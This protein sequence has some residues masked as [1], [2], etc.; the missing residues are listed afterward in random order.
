METKMVLDIHSGQDNLSPEEWSAAEGLWTD[1]DAQVNAAA[2]TAVEVA[3]DGRVKDE[4]VPWSHEGASQELYNLGTLLALKPDHGMPADVEAFLSG[5]LLP[6]G[7]VAPKSWPS[8]VRA[9]AARMI[10]SSPGKA[11]SKEGCE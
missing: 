10:N 5:G 4:P 1:L 9:A 8:E 3:G 11:L 6:Y 7:Y 2:A